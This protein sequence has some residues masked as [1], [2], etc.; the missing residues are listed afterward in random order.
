MHKQWIAVGTLVFLAAG[1]LSGCGG[2][3]SSGA[4]PAPDVTEERN[5]TELK[6]KMTPAQSLERAP[7]SM[8][9]RIPDSMR[10]PATD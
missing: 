2:S 3:G 5:V 9:S 1:V 6:D 10:P 4:A 8:A 7:E